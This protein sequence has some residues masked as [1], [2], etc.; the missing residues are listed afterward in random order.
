MNN[1]LDKTNQNGNKSG[2][3]YMF[4]GIGCLKYFIYDID[5]IGNLNLKIHPAGESFTLFGITL[6]KS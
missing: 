1:E 6:K 2:K 3:E 5:L 4:S